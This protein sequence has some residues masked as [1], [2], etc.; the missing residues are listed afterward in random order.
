MVET[1]APS[2]GAGAFVNLMTLKS[3]RKLEQS[4]TDEVKQI[5]LKA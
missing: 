5:M 1:E 2:Y 4:Y 3:S